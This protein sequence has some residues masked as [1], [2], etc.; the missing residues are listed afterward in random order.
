MRWGAGVVV[1]RGV[2]WNGRPDA[3][4]QLGPPPPEK[5]KQGRANRAGQ[6]VFYAS[7]S[8]ETAVVE[9]RPQVGEWVAVSKWE[10]L[11]PM[12]VNHLGYHA[13][14]LELLSGGRAAPVFDGFDGT[15]YGD[16]NESVT[17]WLAQR[18]CARESDL[19][20]YALSNA[21]AEVHLAHALFDAL[22]FPTVAM[23]GAANNFAIKVPFA[24]ANLR[25]A[26]ARWA[27]VDGRTKDG[28]HLTHSDTATSFPKDVIAWKGHLDQWTGGPGDVLTGTYKGNLE[29]EMRGPDGNVRPPDA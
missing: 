29:W 12:T 22:Q 9:T 2:K 1:Y 25:L 7:D 13:K 21:I 11:V 20:N 18:F 19:F 24:N 5:C 26:K 27:L 15:G 23:N 8:L 10:V 3:V 16:D 14:N 6:P 28:L 4:H 17:Q